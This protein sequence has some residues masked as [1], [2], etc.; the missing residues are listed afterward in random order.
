[1]QKSNALGVYAAAVGVG[2]T[3]PNFAIQPAYFRDHASIRIQPED[4]MAAVLVPKFIAKS[5][6]LQVVVRLRPAHF[7]DFEYYLIG[8]VRSPAMNDDIWDDGPSA[9]IID[10]RISRR[11][12]QS[13]RRAS[14][15]VVLHVDVHLHLETLRDVVR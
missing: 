3:P 5:S 8:V 6:Q 13:L 7:L 14:V 12:V 10:V 1:M 4:N 11:K 15:A 9:Y 2:C